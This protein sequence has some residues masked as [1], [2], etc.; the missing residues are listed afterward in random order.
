MTNN[1][2]MWMWSMFTIYGIKKKKPFQESQIKI[3]HKKLEIAAREIHKIMDPVGPIDSRLQ[4]NNAPDWNRISLTLLFFIRK[5][6]NFIELSRFKQ[7]LMEL[8]LLFMS[9]LN[10][11]IEF[12]LS[13]KYVCCL[14][15]PKIEITLKMLNLLCRPSIRIYQ[16]L[17]GYHSIYDVVWCCWFGVFFFYLCFDH[18]VV[19]VISIVDQ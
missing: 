19:V 15:M 12:I 13:I 17:T 3:R 1:L 7:M 8:L 14:N 2:C 11:K 9:W 18:A 10:Q 4:T 6:L 16:L 5:T